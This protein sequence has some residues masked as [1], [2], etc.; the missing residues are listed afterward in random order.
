MKITFVCLG[1]ICR[2]PM[3][4]FLMKDMVKKN[5]KSIAFEITSAGTSG[6]HDGEDMHKKTKELLLSK[7]IE[8]SGFESKKISQDL[9]DSSDLIFVMD[10]MNYEDVTSRFGKHDKVV[11]IT[12][13]STTKKVTHVP[14]PWFTNNFNETY[15]ILFDCLSNYLKEFE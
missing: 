6:Y 4:E 9:F 14:D 3:G 11:K 1:N 8:C 12:N 15:E 10:D 5:N 2:S 7:N 13:Y